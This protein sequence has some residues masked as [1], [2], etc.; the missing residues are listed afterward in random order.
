MAVQLSL[1]QQRWLEAQVAD[2]HF[3]S[4]EEAVVVAISDLMAV[5]EDE[6]DW[7][8]PLVEAGLAELDRGE[9]VPGDKALASLA[10][11]LDRSRR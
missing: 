11:I 5:S 1:E 4:L 2:G 6:L 7:A 9:V 10:A 3:V 8:R